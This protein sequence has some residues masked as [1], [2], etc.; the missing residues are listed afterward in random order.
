M[1]TEVVDRDNGHGGARPLADAVIGRENG[2][3][4]LTPIALNMAESASKTVPAVTGNSYES[5]A[6]LRSSAAAPRSAGAAEESGGPELDRSRADVRAGK[7][8][9]VPP[10]PLVIRGLGITERDFSRDTVEVSAAFLRFLISELVRPA[11]FDRD[12]YAARYEDIQVGQSSGNIPSPHEHYI[13]HGY[14]ERRLPHSLSIDPD[15]YWRHYRDLTYTYDPSELGALRGHLLHHGWWEGRVGTP[16]LANEAERWVRAVNRFGT[17]VRASVPAKIRKPS[18]EQKLLRNFESLGWNCEFGLVQKYF[19]VEPL[20]LLAFG[21][22]TLDQL[23]TAMEHRFEG[24]GQPDTTSIELKGREFLIVDRKYGYVSH[25]FLHK[26]QTEPHQLLHRG[27][28]RTRL[29]KGKLVRELLGAKK[30]FVHK[31]GPTWPDDA[32][33]RLYH[34]IRAYARNVLLWVDLADGQHQPGDVDRLADGFYKAY[35][36]RFSPVESVDS[37]ISYDVW[38]RICARM[39]DLLERSSR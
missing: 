24:L 35:V 27:C 37:N 23:L 1:A 32:A 28:L 4:A 34:A 25:T 5:P 22:L 6:P 7:R 39:N 31:Q 15:W 36:D 18:P 30:I 13:K 19:N 38:F 26:G 3:M 11:R 8:A 17:Y 29:L 33:S 14:F 12:W 16:D 21:S 2:Q 20:S 10:F 9:Y